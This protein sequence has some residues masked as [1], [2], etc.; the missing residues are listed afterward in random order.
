VHSQCELRSYCTS[1]MYSLINEFLISFLL[2][3]ILFNILF[4][5]VSVHRRLYLYV[6]SLIKTL[7][8][9][10]RLHAANISCTADCI[11]CYLTVTK[12]TINSETI[13]ISFKSKTRANLTLDI[14][15]VSYMGYT[16]CI[17]HEI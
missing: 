9:S 2:Y 8:L 3:D 11:Q 13:Q 7:R 15:Y 5:I 1:N 4:N 12:F 6:Q 16:A 14:Q 17:V 10:V